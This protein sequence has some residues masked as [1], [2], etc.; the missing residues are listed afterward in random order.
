MSRRIDKQKIK[1]WIFTN[2]IV[3]VYFVF[4]ILVEMITVCVVEK[5]P[6]IS[7]PWEALGLL[8]F[9]SGIALLIKKNSFRFIACSVFLVGQVILDLGFVVVY[10][11]TGQYFDY[12]MLNLR[13][14][15]FGILE[16]IP[17]N[18]IVFYTAVLFCVF[19]VIF[20]MRSIIRVKV[21][22]YT[23]KLKVVYMCFLAVGLIMTG[24]AAYANNSAKVDKYEKLLYNKESGKYS[25]YGI[26]GNAINEFAKGLFFNKT[27]IISDNKIES[28]IY[29][30]VSEPTENF[31]VSKDNNVVVILA[32]SLEWFSFIKSD[33]YPNGLRLSDEDIEYLFPNLTKFYDE[34]VVVNNFHSKEK[35][36]ISETISILGSYPTEKYVDYD[37]EE[38]IMPQTIPN[39]LKV[40]TDGKIVNNSFHNGFKS[41]YNRAITHKSFG[42]QM[43]TD[44]YD[45]YEMSDK[46]VQSGK[47]SEAT[48]HDYMNNGERNLDSEMMYTCRDKM[49][50]KDERFFTYI[51][52][53][54]MHG[55]YYEREN[56]EEHRK[57]LLK[58]YDFQDEEDENEKVFMNYLTTA[59]EFDKAIGVM[60]KDLEEKGLLENTTI[61]IFG[62]HNSYY[63]Q[64]SNYVKD[65]FDYDTE[66][67]YTDLYN[68]PL[69]IYD[70]KL[71]HQ[72]IDKFCC[73]SDIAPTLMDL[74]GINYYSN[75]Y[76][77]HSIF[78]EKESVLYSRAYGIFVGNGI[79]GRSLRSIQYKNENIS[80][81]YIKE[82]KKESVNLVEK[83]KY[84][85]QIFYKNYFESDDNYDKYIE[86]LRKINQ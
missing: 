14:D 35:T 52:T 16:S 57:K 25:S 83:I 82:F 44:S 5:N 40:L 62:D 34:S 39:V 9:L 50:P 19:F 21:I 17:M 54:T 37:C 48:M 86:N 26:V 73:T 75:M 10:D 80:D 1:E 58:V 78:D 36:D 23:K 32:E 41:F 51:T 77:G 70:K 24:V 68:V 3:A 72:V 84:C 8:I 38:N 22:E 47:E 79:V 7:N 81:E 60:M 61:L 45:M 65:I 18:F 33:E 74:L 56:L 42:F 49:F 71:G 12:G 55:I 27:E 43:L 59:M 46:F 13:N 11:M 28:Y 20:A 29:K 67:N 63:Q 31:G 85:D 66:K 76:Y 4:A 69:M 64:L 53:I 15:A 30:E 6:F 2:R